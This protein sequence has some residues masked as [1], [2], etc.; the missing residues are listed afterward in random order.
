MAK[1]AGGSG[2]GLVPILIVGAVAVVGAGAWFFMSGDSQAPDN[3]GSQ[4]RSEARR[5]RT[6]AKQTSANKKV[7]PKTRERSTSDT[8]Q[9]EATKR[10]RAS[11]TE[12]QK[13]TTNEDKA[14][15]KKTRKKKRSSSRKKEEKKEEK[16]EPRQSFRD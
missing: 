1:N 8:K 6:K 15:S 3:T 16:S 12:L 13:D 11:T 2:K 9:P 7:A 14:K 5:D 4:V 10:T